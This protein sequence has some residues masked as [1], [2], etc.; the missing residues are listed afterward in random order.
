M[1]YMLPTKFTMEELAS[2]LITAGLNSLWDT[3]DLPPPQAVQSQLKNLP[4]TKILQDQW[5]CRK[6]GPYAAAWGYNQVCFCVQET[7]EHKSLQSAGHQMLA[8]LLAQAAFTACNVQQRWFHP[9]KLPI[10]CN[11]IG[12]QPPIT[13]QSS[14]SAALPQPI[15]PWYCLIQNKEL[16][17][18][19]EQE[20]A[21]AKETK[22]KDV[23]FSIA[24]LN[25]FGLD[26]RW[27]TWEPQAY[28]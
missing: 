7:F 12:K 18:C 1:L 16:T 9:G 20:A 15:C 24:R 27:Q 25:C 3:W 22:L 23:G 13:G 10:H 11:I 28:R 2:L 19:S 4:L 5:A 6:H 26:K 21:Y 8:L 14:L 17:P